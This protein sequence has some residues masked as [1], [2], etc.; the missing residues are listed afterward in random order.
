MERFAPI[1]YT[2]VSISLVYWGVRATKNGR[3][4]RRGESQ[5]KPWIPPEHMFNQDFGLNLTITGLMLILAG[6]VGIVFFLSELL[7]GHGV[8]FE[9][10]CFTFPILLI[11]VINLYNLNEKINYKKPE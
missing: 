4:Y 10:A 8:G 6:I 7:L 9:L 1:I 3:R 11:C 5:Y 2:L